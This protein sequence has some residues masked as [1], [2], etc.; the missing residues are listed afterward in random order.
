MRRRRR[1]INRPEHP[2]NAETE[3]VGFSPTRQTFLARS[4]KPREVFGG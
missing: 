2:Y 3:D 1:I 4:V